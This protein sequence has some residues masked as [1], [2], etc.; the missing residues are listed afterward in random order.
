MVDFK[1]ILFIYT[2]DLRVLH[3]AGLNTDLN[4]K[5]NTYFIV[6]DKLSDR[7]LLKQLFFFVKIIK[8]IFLNYNQLL[9]LNRSSADLRL[10]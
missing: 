10:T 6:N 9:I 3:K 4:T 1:K 5:D 7:I 8:I 2:N